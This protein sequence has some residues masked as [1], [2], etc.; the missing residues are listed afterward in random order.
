MT[1]TSK[2]AYGGYGVF[3]ADEKQVL[4][5]SGKG[6]MAA[7]A[8]SADRLNNGTTTIEQELAGIVSDAEPEQSTEEPEDTYARG[9]G[10]EGRGG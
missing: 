6:A 1:Y 4:V 5:F 7:A 3:D 9:S 10:R 2:K 8:A